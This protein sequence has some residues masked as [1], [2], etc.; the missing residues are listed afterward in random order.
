MDNATGRKILIVEDESDVTDLLALNLR[1][2][3]FKTTAAADGASVCR[4]RGT[5][6]PISSFLT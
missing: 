5:Y 4:R 3:G 6:V 1:K 2:A